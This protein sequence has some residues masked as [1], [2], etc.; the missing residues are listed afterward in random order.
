MD[1][2]EQ[3][4]QEALGPLN[5]VESKNAPSRFYMRGDASLLS[6]GRRVSIV[7]SRAASPEAF[8]RAQALTRIL[9]KEGITI[10]SG[11]A[12][13]IDAAA[14]AEAIKSGGRTIG[15]IGTPL[16]QSY[17]AEHRELQEE[18]AIHHLLLSQFPLGSSS[19]KRNFPM[20]NRTMALISDATVIVEAADGSG[21][22]HQ[23]WEALRL[24]RPLFIM[25]S[26]LGN[27]SL[28]W[29]KEMIQYGAMVLTK[30]SV[31]CL[32]DL[33]PKASR[34]ELASFDF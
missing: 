2:L 6:S 32:I 7:G 14:H 4:P 8:R 19:G 13:G 5:G 25:E 27:L 21:S 15:V 23:G 1:I 33:L 10:V 11:L 30:E 20:R 31:A 17:P 24:G 3:T 34:A 29:P 18:I 9:V 22:L 16:D 12:K 26:I 28:K